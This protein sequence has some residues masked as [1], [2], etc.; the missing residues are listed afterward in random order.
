MGQA[1]RCHPSRLAAP[2][3][4]GLGAGVGVAYAHGDGF[5]MREGK[6]RGVTRNPGGPDTGELHCSRSSPHTVLVDGGMWRWDEGPG[7]QYPA[8]E[9]KRRGRGHIWP[10]GQAQF[11]DQV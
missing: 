2:E 1:L 10:A 9:E 5:Q 8:E 4:R 3:T 7:A 11:S 6:G